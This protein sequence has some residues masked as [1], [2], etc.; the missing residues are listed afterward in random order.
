MN[1]TTIDDL[2]ARSARWRAEAAAEI[3]RFAEDC[4]L[5]AYE[6]SI[7]VARSLAILADDLRQSSVACVSAPGD[8]QVWTA[9]HCGIDEGGFPTDR[10]GPLVMNRDQARQL[11]DILHEVV[12]KMERWEE[13]WKAM[14]GNPHPPASG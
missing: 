6:H 3:Q 10:G 4:D 5:T 12:N 11:A 7:P 2:A 8:G 1:D 13:R 14:R 9:F